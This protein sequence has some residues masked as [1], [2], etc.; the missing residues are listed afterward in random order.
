[1]AMLEKRR[2]VDF[3]TKEMIEL[4]GCKN[5]TTFK[6]RLKKVC[7]R[8]GICIDDFKMNGNE[9]TRSEAF[10]PA[11]CAELVALLIRC[12]EENPAQRENASMKKANEKYINKYYRLLLEE[13]EKLP[14]PLKKVVYA[15]PSHYVTK[16]IVLWSEEFV[17]RLTLFASI[18][19]NEGGDDV[20]AL[21]KELTRKI[22]KS[23]YILFFSKRYIDIISGGWD[24][25]RKMKLQEE[26]PKLFIGATKGNLDDPFDITTQSNIGLDNGI[27]KYIK[28]VMS[29]MSEIKEQIQYDSPK[30]VADIQSVRNDF[31][32]QSIICYRNQNEEEISNAATRQHMRWK[33]MDE[34]IVDEDILTKEAL[35]K[36]YDSEIAFYEAEIFALNSKKTMLDA[37]GSDDLVELIHSEYVKTCREVHHS[38]VRESTEKYVGELLWYFLNNEK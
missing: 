22:D 20:G 26:N 30:E 1:M 27:A 15:L 38:G 34:R 11:E 12:D 25:K 36:F 28:Y 32:E 2:A 16:E 10:Y 4:S 33:S 29:R 3:S 6:N 19:M 17:K 35:Y 23:T 24:K 13:V 31:Y 14:L 5:E 8:Y 9:A 18:Y 37:F 21:M 7:N